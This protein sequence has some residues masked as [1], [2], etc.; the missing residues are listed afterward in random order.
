L[1]IIFSDTKRIFIE[2]HNPEQLKQV[3]MQLASKGIKGIN[4]QPNE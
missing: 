2:T 4:Q 3:L 1:Q